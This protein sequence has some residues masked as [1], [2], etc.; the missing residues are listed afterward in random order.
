M[1]NMAPMDDVATQTARITK[2]NLIEIKNDLKHHLASLIDK[3]LDP[4]MEQLTTLS[5]TIKDMA[6]TA[7]AALEE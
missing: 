3:K 2:N 5:S 1:A 6:V 4:L 7:N